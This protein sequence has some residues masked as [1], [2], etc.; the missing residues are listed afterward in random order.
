[1]SM[2]EDSI[3]KSLGMSKEVDL[4]DGQSPLARAREQ[5]RKAHRQPRFLLDKSPTSLSAYFEERCAFFSD[6]ED[7]SE[8]D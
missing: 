4:D 8:E 6:D 5:I 3:R 1:M 2:F 7:E